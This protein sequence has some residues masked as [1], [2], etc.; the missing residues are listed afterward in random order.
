MA[1]AQGARGDHGDDEESGDAME[2]ADEHG[3]GLNDEPGAQ[4]KPHAR[5]GAV[6]LKS[7]SYRATA[8]LPRAVPSVILPA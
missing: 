6:L 2:S 8:R 4:R 1:G 5:Y 7:F 3:V